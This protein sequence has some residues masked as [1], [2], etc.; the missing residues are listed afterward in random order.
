MTG[1]GL[2]ITVY[3]GFIFMWTRIGEDTTET[4]IGTDTDGTMN[5]FLTDNFD[6]TG[7]AGR[8][9]DIGKGKEEIGVSRAINVG[10]N[11]RWRN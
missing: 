5:G 6:R 9:I 11:G 3:Q 8:M 1:V 7:D 10:R 2:F 4:T